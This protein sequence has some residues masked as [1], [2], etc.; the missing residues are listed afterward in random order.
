MKRYDIKTQIYMN[1]TTGEIGPYQDWW[2]ETEDGLTVNAVDRKEVTPVV[3]SIE[4]KYWV[5][6]E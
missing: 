5:E 4:G 2:Y 1:A 3:W 6:S